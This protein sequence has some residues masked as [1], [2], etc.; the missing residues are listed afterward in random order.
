M[1]KKGTFFDKFDKN[2]LLKVEITSVMGG[3]V[4]E[5]GSLNCTVETVEMGWPWGTGTKGDTDT[6]TDRVY[7]S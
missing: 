6:D 7:T 2:A 5:T 1:N 3:A 4:I